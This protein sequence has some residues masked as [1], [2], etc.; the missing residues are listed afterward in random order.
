[1]KIR[2]VSLATLTLAILLAVPAHAQQS[3][4]IQ[5]RLSVNVACPNATYFGQVGIPNSD[6]FPNVQLTDPDGDGVFTGSLTAP[7]GEQ[8][9]L[10]RLVQGT[11]TIIVEPP[12]SGPQVV[13]GQPSRVV[14]DF[15]TPTLTEDTVLE[16]SV[17]NCIGAALPST[18]VSNT[19]STS[20]LIGG[21]LLLIAGIAARQRMRVLLA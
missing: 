21:L 12:T 7:A 8:L 17:S 11:G 1:M 14:R 6:G 15:G 9:P 18:G 19:V 5:F 2:M 13:P 10:L 16:A 20:A 4:T 3:V